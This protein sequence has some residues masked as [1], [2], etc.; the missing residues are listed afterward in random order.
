MRWNFDVGKLVF[1]FIVFIIILIISLPIVMVIVV[2][3]SSSGF[4]LPPSGLTLEWYIKAFNYKVFRSGIYVSF[5]VAITSSV[6]ATIIGTMASFAFVRYHFKYK[7]LV[8]IFFM[9]PLMI[10]VVILSLAIYIFLVRVGLS[11]GVLA[12]V[13]G[14][15]VL[16]IPFS[17]RTVTASLQNFDISLEEAAINVGAVPTTAIFRITLPI[18]KTGI[19]AGTMMSFIISWNNYALSIFLVKPG[20]VTL[21][22]QLFDYIKFEWDPSSAAIASFLIFLSGV[23]I[24]IIDRFIGLSVVMGIERKNI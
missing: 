3:F 10:P 2:S 24:I 16:I 21:P 7:N 6:I 18:I 13:I 4:R 9:S 23:I 5:L 19:I 22:I 1:N 11:G 14:H 20:S 8:N 12:L 15:T 17:I